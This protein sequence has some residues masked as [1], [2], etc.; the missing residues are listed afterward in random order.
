M[1]G[2]VGPHEI[3]THSQR[4]CRLYKKAYRTTES[5]ALER[6]TFRFNAVVL[7]ARFDE[8]RS[9]KDMRILAQMLE[10]GEEESWREQHYDPSFLRMTP[11]VLS[12][13]ERPWHRTGFSTSGILG[14]RF[15]P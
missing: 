3:L 8:T 6:Y 10:D 2:G 9:I 12:R 14:R 4:V 7:R 11:V 1:P 13:T 5:W 15:R